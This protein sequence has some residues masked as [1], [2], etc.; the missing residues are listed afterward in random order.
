[1]RFL[2]LAVALLPT[3]V[4]TKDLSAG[5]NVVAVAPP[6]VGKAAKTPGEQPCANATARLVATADKA[7]AAR[8]LSEEPSANRYLP[9]QRIVGGCDRPVMIGT[10]QESGH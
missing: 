4:Q 3:A 2:V 8:P 1:M 9:V 6:A 7:I 10:H 5:A